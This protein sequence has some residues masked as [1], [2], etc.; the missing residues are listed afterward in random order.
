MT[1]TVAANIFP[2][3]TSCAKRINSKQVMRYAIIPLHN[4]AADTHPPGTVALM[5]ASAPGPLIGSLRYHPVSAQ[6]LWR[7]ER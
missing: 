2:P 5:L 7:Q 4:E 1:G 3:R 6:F